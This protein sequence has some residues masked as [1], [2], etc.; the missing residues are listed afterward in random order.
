MLQFQ[1]CTQNFPPNYEQLHKYADHSRS[2][3]ALKICPMLATQVPIPEL[4][5]ARMVVP[6]RQ[7]LVLIQSSHS[8]FS[9][10][11]FDFEHLNETVC[12][13]GTGD[14]YKNKH[15]VRVVQLFLSPKWRWPKDDWNFV[16]RR[17]FSEISTHHHKDD[18]CIPTRGMRNFFLSCTSFPPVG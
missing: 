10:R 11:P 18:S 2:T 15:S 14:L 16:P 12:L 4:S 1:S 8:P 6:S 17:L 5:L 7:L 13:T 3:V 9:L